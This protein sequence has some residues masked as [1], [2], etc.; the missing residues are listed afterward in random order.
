M[1]ISMNI[2]FSEYII[3]NEN[4]QAANHVSIQVIS[5]IVSPILKTG[6][7]SDGT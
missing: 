2:K 1:N 5:I 6:N 3:N 4:C 7:I